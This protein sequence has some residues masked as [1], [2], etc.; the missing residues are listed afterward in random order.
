VV[1][2][3][4]VNQIPRGRSDEIPIN[5]K[6]VLRVASAELPGNPERLHTG[7]YG[8][9]LYDL[10]LMTEAVIRTGQAKSQV[11]RGAHEE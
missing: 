6:A 7:K 5:M 9:T 10:F 2:D 8:S 3:L 1:E 11:V 4:L